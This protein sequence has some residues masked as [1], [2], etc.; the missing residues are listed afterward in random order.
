MNITVQIL[1]SILIVT[2]VLAILVYAINWLL[3]LLTVP[4]NLKRIAFFIIGLLYLVY[5]L[6]ALN[7]YHVAL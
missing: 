7:I 1:I 6:G 5:L 2:I 4:M 3:D